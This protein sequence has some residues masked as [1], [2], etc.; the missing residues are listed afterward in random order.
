[1]HLIRQ[2][3]DLILLAEKA[4]Q[5]KTDLGTPEVNYPDYLSFH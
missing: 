4:R 2:N 1:M 3:Y 5:T